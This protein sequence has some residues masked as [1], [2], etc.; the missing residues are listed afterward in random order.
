MAISPRNKSVDK[1]TAIKLINSY[2]ESY[3]ILEEENKRLKNQI[4]DMSENLKVNK[5]IVSSLSSTNLKPDEK[6][7]K[8]I[9]ELSVQVEILL[10]KN[11]ELTKGIADTQNKVSNHILTLLYS[12]DNNLPLK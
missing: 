12:Y 6:S 2:A 3:K 1:K 4:K 7:T 5:S 11:K 10:E 9:N 8:I